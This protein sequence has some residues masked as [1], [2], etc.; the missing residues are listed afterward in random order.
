MLAKLD[1]KWFFYIINCELLLGAGKVTFLQE[2]SCGE[3]SHRG[4]GGRGSSLQGARRR[5]HGSKSSAAPTCAVVAAR[6][7]LPPRGAGG[8][9]LRGLC[10]NWGVSR[11]QTQREVRAALSRKREQRGEPEGPRPPS[12]RCDFTHAGANPSQQGTRPCAHFTDEKGEA[13][14]SRGH[15]AEVT[16]WG[17]ESKWRGW[18]WGCEQPVCLPPP[19]GPTWSPL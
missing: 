2:T 4:Q 6:R 16:G 19:L 1:L 15:K 9:R 18:Q 14:A 7:L 10:R 13:R 3:G 5:C 17:A 12:R 11:G 8:T